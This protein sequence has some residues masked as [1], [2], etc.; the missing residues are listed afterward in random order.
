MSKW[1]YVDYLL[2]EIKKGAIT[3]NNIIGTTNTGF[4]YQ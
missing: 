3:N 4:V 1:Y 2:E